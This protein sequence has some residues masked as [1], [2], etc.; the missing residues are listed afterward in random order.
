VERRDFLHLLPNPFQTGSKSVAPLTPDEQTHI[1]DLYDAEVAYFDEQLGALL[2]ELK[3][4]GLLDSTLIVVTADHGE[5][6]FDHGQFGHGYTLY[7]ELL[8]VPLVLA[9]PLAPAG[10]RCDVPVS[11]SGLAAALMKIVGTS[12]PGVEPALLPPPGKSPGPVFSTVRTGLFGPRHVLVSGADGEGRKVILVHDENDQLA[13][14]LHFD[15][16]V[17]PGEQHPLAV[18]D[19]PAAERSAFDALQ[20][21]AADWAERTAKACPPGPQPFSPAIAKAL[22]DIGYVGDKKPQ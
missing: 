6:L 11:S 22:K 9:G 17:D 19:L 4:R 8:H 10:T 3:R 15:L 12:S 21:A 1:V 7:D 18:A 16:K 5:E 20:A 13:N 14:V 2:V